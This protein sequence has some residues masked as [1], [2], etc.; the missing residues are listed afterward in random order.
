MK[1]SGVL[2]GMMV[3]MGAGAYLYSYIEKHPIKIELSKHKIED[4]IKDLK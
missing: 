1:K 4:L 3:G 2:F